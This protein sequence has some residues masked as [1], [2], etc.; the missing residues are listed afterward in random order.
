MASPFFANHEKT[1]PEPSPPCPPLIAAV[2][3]LNIRVFS[4]L[5]STALTGLCLFV[6]VCVCLHGDRAV[7]FVNGPNGEDEEGV[8]AETATAPVDGSANPGS[9]RFGTAPG[10]GSGGVALPDDNRPGY[11]ENEP[12]AAK[13]A[14]PAKG[15]TAAEPPPAWRELEENGEDGRGDRERARGMDERQKD[16]END[17]PLLVTTERLTQEVAQVMGTGGGYL[18]VTCLEVAP[19]WQDR[20]AR[21]PDAGQKIRTGAYHYRFY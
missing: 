16:K 5:A 19:T 6:C 3:L 17:V 20:C 4:L 14:V 12:R 2:D 1:F 10:G 9:D 21:M 13:P 18:G 8:T 15:D 7:S 11:G